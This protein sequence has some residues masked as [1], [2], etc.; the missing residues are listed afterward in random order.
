MTAK[1]KQGRLSVFVPGVP[2]PKGNL[3]H[4]P[5]TRRAYDATKGLSEWMDAVVL[6]ARNE[7]VQFEAGVPLAVDTLYVMPRPKSHYNKGGALGK[8]AAQTYWHLVKPD[9][10]KLDRAVFDALVR[11]GVAVDDAQFCHGHRSKRYTQSG[12][13][14]G[15]FVT[16]EAL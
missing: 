5:L 2:K 4:N 11:A 1:R 6:V 15:V 14:P 13:S 9:A 12:E 3:R 7:R 16:V 8:R 10:D